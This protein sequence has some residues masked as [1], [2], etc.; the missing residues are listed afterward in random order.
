VVAD[1][2]PALR[3]A[4]KYRDRLFP[5]VPIAFTGVASSRLQGES[6]RPG[7]TGVALTTDVRGCVDL[8]FRFHPDTQRVALIAGTSEFERYWQ[9]EIHRELNRYADRLTAIELVGLPAKELLRQVATRPPHTIVFFQLIFVEAAQPVIGTYDILEAVSQR[10]PT[11]CVMNYCFDHGGVGGSYGTPYESEARVSE[12]AARILAGERPEDI[13]IV[14]ASG[15]RVQVDWRQLRKWNIRESALP[16]GSIVLYRQ[17]TVWERYRK[18]MTVGILLIVFQALLII[19]LLWQRA[20]KRSSEATLRESEQ[21]FRVM[22]DTAPSLIWMCDKEGRVTYRSEKYVALTGGTA[23]SGLGAGWTAYI[24]A[25]DLPNVLNADSW[26]LERQEASSK[27]YRLLRRDGVYRW[28]LDIASPRLDA[29]GSFG[30][31]IGSAIDITDQKV[32]REALEK[33]GGRL[34]EAQE[35]ERSRIAR[36]LHDDICQRLALLSLELEQANQ[37]SNGSVGRGMGRSMISENIAPRSPRMSKPY[38]MSF[39]LR[40]SII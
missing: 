18:F 39:T 5:G 14:Y 26:A 38:H 31:L 33:I 6:L 36:E 19:G 20:R 1:A 17:P 2:Y 10:F 21:R 12:L 11:Y 16:A 30:G 25:D 3:F 37:S 9:S 7:V 27:E 23:E 28:M 22:V 32:A 35:K 29:N 4:I 13:P 8:A 24:H 40:S 15:H 34:I